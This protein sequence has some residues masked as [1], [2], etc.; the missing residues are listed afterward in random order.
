VPQNRSFSADSE[1]L[2]QT[3]LDLASAIGSENF[4]PIF[5]KHGMGDI[6]PDRWY[7]IPEL[8]LAIDEVSQRAGSM[9]DLVSLGMKGAEMAVVPPEFYELS[10]PELFQAMN[11]AY[12]VNVRGTDPG[13]IK[14]EILSDHHIRL[15]VRVPFPDDEWYGVC[16]GYMRRF[17]PPETQFTVYYDDDIPRRDQGGDV[18]VIHV[19]WE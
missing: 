19:E 9:L 15:S 12:R 1:I 3:M 5:E 7:P 2:G 16:Y 17:A 8:L 4:L 14:C 6:D 10:I 11:D 13:E 18:T